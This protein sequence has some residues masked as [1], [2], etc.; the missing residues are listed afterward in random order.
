MALFTFIIYLFALA[1][2]YPFQLFKK[3]KFTPCVNFIPDQKITN[4]NTTEFFWH[5]DLPIH[6]LFGFDDNEGMMLRGQ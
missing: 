2:I 3:M 4:A 5:L 6:A 1:V